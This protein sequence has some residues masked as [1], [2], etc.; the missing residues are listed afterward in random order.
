[1]DKIKVTPQREIAVILKR[2][3][4]RSNTYEAFFP[5]IAVALIYFALI[6][7]VT[8]LMGIAKKKTDPK[9]RKNKS[10]LKILFFF[11]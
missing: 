9:R 11:T 8:M 10:I 3:T 7:I 4:P 2:K 6:W 5:L 1:M